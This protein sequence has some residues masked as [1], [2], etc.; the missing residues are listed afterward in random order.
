MLLNSFARDYPFHES[1]FIQG[2]RDAL[3]ST[4]QLTP[5]VRTISGFTFSKDLGLRS[6]H[7]G[8]TS[9]GLWDDDYRW[10]A[11]DKDRSNLNFC[12]FN[13]LQSQEYFKDPVYGTRNSSEIFLVGR[14]NARDQHAS[15]QLNLGSCLF[16]ADEN[17]VGITHN[18]RL[19]VGKSGSAKSSDVLQYV[20]SEAPY[21]IGDD[22]LVHLGNVRLKSH[23]SLNDPDVYDL[24]LR[25]AIYAHYR[26]C[27]RDTIRKRSY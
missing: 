23:Y 11:L 20:K 14:G 15:L 9:G 6:T 2:L 18:G 16:R 3:H 13:I 5:S 4:E 26:D 12:M 10:I 17:T 7:I 19:T 21:L 27:F 22:E 8:N 1:G 24:L 25:S